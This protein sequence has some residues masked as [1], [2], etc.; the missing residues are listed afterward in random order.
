MLQINVEILGQKNVREILYK[1]EQ[2]KR[3]TMPLKTKKNGTIHELHLKPQ[4]GYNLFFGK[5][6][7]PEYY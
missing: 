2:I 7:H 1:F 6:L 5:M 4:L 3:R